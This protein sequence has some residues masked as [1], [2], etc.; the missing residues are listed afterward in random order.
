MTRGGGLS[1]KGLLFVGWP[2]FFKDDLKLIEIVVLQFQYNCEAKVDL[3]FM[4][5]C[6]WID[7]YNFCCGISSLTAHRDPR[8]SGEGTGIEFAREYAL[9][10]TSVRWPGQKLHRCYFPAISSLLILTAA[11]GPRCG[12]M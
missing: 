6:V 7:G 2:G 3:E 8:F 4:F 1:R 10:L 5:V 12:N 9:A 11:R